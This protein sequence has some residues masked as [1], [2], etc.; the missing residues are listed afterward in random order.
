MPA[1]SQA[2]AHKMALLYKQGKIS[3]KT[4]DDFVKGV[5]VKTLPKHVK[6]KPRRK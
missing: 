5:K 6:K 4:L 3:K 1:R 2:Q